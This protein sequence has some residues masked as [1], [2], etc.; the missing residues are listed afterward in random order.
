MKFWKMKLW[1]RTSVRVAVLA[2]AALAIGATAYASIPDSGGVIH[3]CYLKGV[4]TLRVIDS[5]SQKCFTAIETPIQWNQ[6]GPQGP[7]G[8]QGARGSTGSAG[9]V[10]GPGPKG[11]TGP[12]G[13]AGGASTATF[14]FTTQPTE[15]QPEDAGFTDVLSRDLPAGSWAVSATVNL[16]ETNGSFGPSHDEIRNTECEIRNTTGGVIG[17]ATD[18]RVIPEE[19]SVSPSLAFNGGAAIPS[20]GGNVSLYCQ[21]AADGTSVDEAQMM[22][23]QVGGL[24]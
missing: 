14:S 7:P 1:R 21:S 11:D 2:T 19:D 22:F 20:G 4:G 17:S 13:N 3:G 12:Q 16:T 15:L 24:S 5:P 8:P 10:G 18:R 9:P 23:I 6:T